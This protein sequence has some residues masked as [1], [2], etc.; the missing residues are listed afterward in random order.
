MSSLFNAAISLPKCPYCPGDMLKHDEKGNVIQIDGIDQRCY[1]YLPHRYLDANIG[2]E[3]WKIDETNFEGEEEDLVKIK[4]YFSQIEKLKNSGRGFYISGPTYGSGKTTLGILFLK[5]VLSTTRYSALF[6]P[7]SELVVI[8][9]KYM[10]NHFDKTLD[11]KI[12]YIKNVDF[13]MIDDLGKEFDNNKD[14][15]R[16]ALNSIL[17]Y[18]VAWQKITVFTSNLEIKDLSDIYG[19][20]N[21]SIIS[22][23]SIII[24]IKNREDF[25]K[26]K[27]IKALAEE[28][29]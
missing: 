26:T 6:I 24:P 16:N 4:P 3:Y 12:E 2:F 1:C 17:R 11:E 29:K 15:G 8:N 20:S 13:L 9:A 22:G 27:K 19:G 14:W 7:C 10:Q 23:Y 5:K 25:R 21:Q 28:K 18:R